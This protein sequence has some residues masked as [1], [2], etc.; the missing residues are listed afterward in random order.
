[1]RA[2]VLGHPI[3]HSLSPVLHNT[4]YQALGLARRTYSSSC[5][6]AEA[7]GPDSETEGWTYGA[8]DVAPVEIE[9][10]WSS[11]DPETGERWAFPQ[12]PKGFSE[13]LDQTLVDSNEWAGFSLTM[14]LKNLVVPWLR[15]VIQSDAAT[16]GIDPMVHITGSANTLV[17]NCTTFPITTRETA[18]LPANAHW[19]FRDLE[20]VRPEISAFNTDVYGIVAALRE[21]IRHGPIESIAIIGTGA[22]ACSAIAAARQLGATTVVAYG[23]RHSFTDSLYETAN[24]L[25]YQRYRGFQ[26]R[27]LDEAPAELSEYDAV[28]STIPPHAADPLAAQLIA[29]ALPSAP[30]GAN[31]VAKLRESPEVEA[32]RSA[33]PLVETRGLFGTLL[34]VVYDPSPTE[35]MATWSVLG[36]A[37]VGGERMLLHQAAKQVE[38]MTGQ[39]APLA[40]MEAALNDALAIS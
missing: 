35:L 31:T 12:P 8:I 25:G 17:K 1:M 9:Y 13:L 16:V 32:H 37:V 21:V 40:A 36:G 28:I 7:Q 34:D 23:R 22:T 30:E 4:A 29:A 14:P 5:G 24:L 2:A 10:V 27:F 18:Q 39:P 33:P 20:P 26:S 38:L 11:E 19:P 3:A 15:T 6:P